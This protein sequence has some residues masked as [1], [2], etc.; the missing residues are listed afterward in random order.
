MLISSIFLHRVK[1]FTFG[2]PGFTMDI[3]KALAVGNIA[4]QLIY[5]SYDHL[6][7]LAKS[8]YPKIRKKQ[9]PEV[10]VEEVETGKDGNAAEVVCSVVHK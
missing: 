1:S 5:T 7:P 6:S 8:Y 3:P 10:I 9:A 4:V 2:E